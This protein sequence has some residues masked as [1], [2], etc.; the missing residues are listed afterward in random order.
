MNVRTGSHATHGDA[1]AVLLELGFQGVETTLQQCPRL[2]AGQRVFAALLDCQKKGKRRCD[3]L[4]C[5]ARCD[6]AE[7]RHTGE[8]TEHRTRITHT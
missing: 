5:G 7:A 1:L 6:P 8:S 4:Q 3:K 2:P